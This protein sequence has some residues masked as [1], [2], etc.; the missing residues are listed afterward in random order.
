[1]LTMVMLYD[2][3]T[4]IGALTSSNNLA[5]QPNT[6][7]KFKIIHQCFGPHI[8]PTTHAETT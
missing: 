5:K 1:M 8:M 2:A 6:C 3:G 7:N 4:T